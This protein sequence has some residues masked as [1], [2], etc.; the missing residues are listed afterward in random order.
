MIRSRAAACLIGLVLATAGVGALAAPPREGFAADPPAR[1]TEKQWV[2]D[3]AWDKGTGTVATAK[4][5]D[6]KKPI[7]TARSMGRF[8]LELWVGKEL[9]DRVRFDVPLLGDD[10]PYREPKAFFKKP[11]FQRVTTKIK[12]QMADSPRATVLAFVD[13]STGETKKY[14]WPPD[15]KGQLTPF[16]TKTALGDPSATPS[17]A[18]AAT[19]SVAVA[20]TSVAVAPTSA[21]VAPTSAPVAPGTGAPSSVPIAPTSTPV[22]PTST[23]VAPKPSVAPT[24]AP[25]VPHR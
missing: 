17:S 11:T 6:A 23:P 15:E 7:A 25:V 8:A 18:P 4:S 14:F 10:S 21:P 3:V 24:S 22:A 9:L 2:F 19:L 1:A 5:A 16:A 13:R 12:V 20:P